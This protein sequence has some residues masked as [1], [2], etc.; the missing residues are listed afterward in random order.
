LREDFIDESHPVGHGEKVRNARAGTG[1]AQ[2]KT[3]LLDTDDFPLEFCEARRGAD[4]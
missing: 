2:L 4:R 3:A 1:Q